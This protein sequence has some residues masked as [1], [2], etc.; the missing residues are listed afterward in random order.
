MFK[1]EHVRPAVVADGMAE[2]QVAFPGVPIVFCE[3][4]QLAEEWTYRFLAAAY[5]AA[6]HSAEAAPIVPTL[7]EPPTMPEPSTAEVRAWARENGLEVPAKGRL[8]PQVWEAYRR[9]HT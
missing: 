3:S 2:L 5:A 4:R 6:G 9:A 1:L 8:R 7:D